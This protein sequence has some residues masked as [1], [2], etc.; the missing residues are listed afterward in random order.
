MTTAVLVPPALTKV[1][2]R[3]FLRNGKACNAWLFSVGPR[4]IQEWQQWKCDK[5][6]TIETFEP[7]E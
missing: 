7:V 4:G 6:G 1:L 2:C 3:G 5:C